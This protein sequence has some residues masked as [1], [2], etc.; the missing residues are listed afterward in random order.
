[1]SRKTMAKMEQEIQLT[2]ERIAYIN[3]EDF[4]DEVISWLNDLLYCRNA[5]CHQFDYLEVANIEA[6]IER[7]RKEI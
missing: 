2:K 7:L 6:C 4:I 1:M 3:R 5:S